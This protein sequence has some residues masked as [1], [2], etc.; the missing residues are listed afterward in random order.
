[1]GSGSVSIAQAK[2]ASRGDTRRLI[3]AVFGVW[4]LM[5]QSLLPTAGALA[6]QSGNGLLIE[7]CTA[8]GFQTLIV[9][10]DADDGEERPTQSKSSAGCDVCVTCGCSM[11]AGSC[12]AMASLTGSSW[13][14]AGW[15]VP[16]FGVDTWQTLAGFQARG[17]PTA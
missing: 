7:L 1:M 2:K 13:T 8:A 14:W 9:D 17:P 6:A 10:S 15:A 5:L 12:G 11:G 3:V 16:A 4:A